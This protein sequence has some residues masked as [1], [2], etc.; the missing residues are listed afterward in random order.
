MTGTDEDFGVP[1]DENPEWTEE[2]FARARKGPPWNWRAADALRGSAKLLREEAER[3]RA[4]ADRLDAEAE[5]IAPAPPR[6]R[7]RMTTDQQR[8]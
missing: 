6:H 4:E 5:E 7:S 8:P 2:D 3:L 1:D